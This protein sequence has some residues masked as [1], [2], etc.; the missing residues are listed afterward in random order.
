M[1][2]CDGDHT[3]GREIHLIQRDQRVDL[4]EHQSGKFATGPFAPGRRQGM[5]PRNETIGS[6]KTLG[7]T[8]AGTGG[9]GA[10]YSYGDRSGMAASCLISPA[11]QA[12][13]QRPLF[14][15]SGR[16]EST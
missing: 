3:V 2:Q 4:I 12:V 11:R 5:R 7:Q 15:L 14:A 8:A 10:S 1:P 13:R 9:A 16:P 6:I